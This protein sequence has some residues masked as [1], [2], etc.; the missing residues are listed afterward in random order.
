MDFLLEEGFDENLIKQ[1]KQRYDSSTLDLFILERENVQDVIHYFQ[2]IGIIPIEELLLSRIELFTK[3][4][5]TIKDAFLKHNI[6]QVVE[7]VN[8]DINNIDWL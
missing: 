1:L 2:K 5:N 7:L 4:I 8:H 3:D 6:K